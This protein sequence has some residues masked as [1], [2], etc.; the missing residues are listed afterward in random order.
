MSDTASVPTSID[1]ATATSMR[2]AALVQLT[3]ARNY[4][5]DL[6]KATPHELWL[7]IPPGGS[8][9]VL[10]QVGHIAVAEY[11]LLLFRMRGRAEIDLELVPGR[12]RKGYGR[13]S[14]PSTE[15]DQPTPTEMLSRLTT[16]HDL[17]MQEIKTGR[18]SDCWNRSTC[19]TRVMQTSWVRY[20]LPQCMK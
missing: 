10:W 18:P 5:L 1:L 15:A 4:T 3:F 7:T 2:D 17:G 16:I 12:F 20:Y 8:S 13:G 14:Q 6:L 19:R 11:G 9:H